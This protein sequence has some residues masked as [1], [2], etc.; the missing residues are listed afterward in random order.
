MVRVGARFVLVGGLVLWCSIAGAAT[1][2]DG[3]ALTGDQTW[4]LAGSPYIVRGDVTVPAGSSLTIEPG[5]EVQ[6]TTGDS[7]AAGLDQ[8]RVELTVEGSLR[9]QGTLSAPIV[10]HPQT[11]S[12]ALSWY[13][14]VIS[15]QAISAVLEHVDIEGANNGLTNLAPG[16]V[17][18][19]SDSTF[20]HNVAGLWLSAGTP[21]LE[22]LV[23]S[24]NSA[25][26][27]YALA[28]DAMIA[29]SLS[30]SV[31]RSNGSYGVYLSAALGH[32]V[33]ASITN[34]TIHGND[35]SGVT[36]QASGA[37]SQTTLAISNTIVSSNGI[38]GIDS[39]QNNDGVVTISTSYSDVFS[40]GLDYSETAPGAGC[41][42]ADPGYVM[43]PVDL[44]LS[45]QSP[46]ID[47][48]SAS[49]APVI[50]LLGTACPIG[51]GFDIGA[52]EYD[53]NAM[54]SDAGAAG[55]AGT[56]GA[57]SAEGGSASTPQPTSA[58]DK[59]GCGCRMTT[60]P[61]PG[62]FWLGVSALLLLSRR[63]RTVRKRS[64]HSG[65]TGP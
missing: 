27:L 50:D 65:I 14:V 9:A 23:L 1:T 31:A 26:G 24:E 8:N 22:R 3:G 57:A 64:E 4:A 42:S 7:Q 58:S 45:S 63:F 48:G 18:A 10:L 25:D 6:F 47:A 19:L 56:A 33:S 36:G 30:S 55:A 17:L 21:M 16:N 37:G 12:N 40:N 35:S 39:S 38:T 44:R 59:S 15:A 60:K 54:P 46:C 49:G 11:D 43:P 61:T 5:V 13:G 62:V 32:S 34:C 52:Y 2:L 41:L 29:F 51:A 53:P 20:S 28:N